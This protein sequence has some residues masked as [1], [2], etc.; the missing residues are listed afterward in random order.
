MLYVLKTVWDLKYS[1]VYFRSQT[2][3]LTWIN[4]YDRDDTNAMLALN[5]EHL[6]LVQSVLVDDDHSDHNSS[7]DGQLNLKATT[8]VAKLKELH[9]FEVLPKRW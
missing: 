1:K 4:V 8:Q 5:A 3:Y 2:V 7:I 6:R 9:Q